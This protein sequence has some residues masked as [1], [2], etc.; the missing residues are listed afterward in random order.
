M[1]KGQQQQGREPHKILCTGT[2][3]QRE[4]LEKP[5]GLAEVLGVG[6]SSG[7]VDLDT[8]I[9]TYRLEHRSAVSPSLAMHPGEERI[10]IFASNRPGVVAKIVFSSSDPAAV[11]PVAASVGEIEVEAKIHVVDVKEA[12]RGQDLG[13]LLFVEAMQALRRRYS[14]RIIRCQLDAEE[15]VSRHNRL[16]IFYKRLGCSVKPNAKVQYLNNMHN[17]GEAYRKVPMVIVLR[18]ATTSVVCSNTVPL[19]SNNSFLPVNRLLCEDGSE[20]ALWDHPSDRRNRKLQ[21]ILIDDGRGHFRFRTTCG[22]HL[23]AT[24]N[25]EVC[26]GGD[27]HDDSL[28]FTFQE[29]SDNNPDNFHFVSDSEESD[30][31]GEG[32][33]RSPLNT[34]VPSDTLWTI[35]TPGT[36]LFLTT[37]PCTKSLFLSPKATLWRTRNKDRNL[38]C[39][40]KHSPRR[41]HCR[42]AWR[43]QTVASVNTW[44]R[45]FLKFELCTMSIKD[46]LD[47][48]STIPLYMYP[49]SGDEC[50]SQ[51]RSLRDFCYYV[52]EHFRR[53]GCPDWLVFVALV[54]EL[55][56]CV[57]LV[58]KGQKMVD[59]INNDDKHDYDWTVACHSRIVG[60]RRPSQAS[61]VHDEFR[62]LCPDEGDPLYNTELGIYEEGCGLSDVHVLMQWSGPEYLYFML[63]RNGATLPELALQIIRYFSLSD[64][65]RHGK[66][67]ALSNASDEMNRSI[68]SEFDDTRRNARR[69][70]QNAPDLSDSECERLWDSIYCNIVAKYGCGGDLSW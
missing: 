10:L 62:T 69:E 19:S 28:V 16:I 9:F 23:F 3:M 14:G 26:V 55:G 43:C 48:A 7:T 52:A 70:C 34:W 32:Y 44:R 20:I 6:C 57:R 29:A 40:A 51:S 17:D 5:I 49:V 56:R 37:D 27:G 31:D 25:G 21:W 65:H 1:A 12:H 18:P 45:A 58:E 61:P 42:N 33:E 22:R 66:Y 8:F 35:Q 2:D 15:D 64:W 54:H 30:N 38:T 11:A 13:G 47:L 53:D 24:S 46:A 60:C 4:S 36:R 67:S 63:R 41:I 39:L 68:V 59:E 50:S